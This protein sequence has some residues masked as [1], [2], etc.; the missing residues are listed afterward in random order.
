MKKLVEK[1]YLILESNRSFPP[2]FFIVPKLD[3][4]F[5]SSKEYKEVGVIDYPTLK[6]FSCSIFKKSGVELHCLGDLIT[7]TSKEVIDLQKEADPDKIHNILYTNA[8]LYIGKFSY[9]FEGKRKMIQDLYLVCNKE[10]LTF[11]KEKRGYS[12]LLNEQKLKKGERTEYR[13]IESLLNKSYGTFYLEKIA[14]LYNIKKRTC[15]PWD[16]TST[17]FFV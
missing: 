5:L 10:E 11:K 15:M 8:D 13:G 3:F 9:L 12:L 6:N 2:N 7:L 4:E 1:Y 17:I 14:T 16:R